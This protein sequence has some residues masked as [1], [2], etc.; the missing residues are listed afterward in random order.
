MQ[1]V[2]LG[3][4]IECPIVLCLG[5]F[6]SMHKGHVELLNRAK[7][8]AQATNCK[9]ALF[10]FNNNHLAVLKRDAKLLY[11]LNERLLIYESLNIDYVITANF[12]AD[13]R[14]LSGNQ[15][16]SEFNQYNLQSVFCGFDHCCGRDH[17][18]ALGIQR[19]F[20]RIPVHIVEQ[21]SVDGQKVSTTL[22]REYVVSNQIEKANTLLSEPFFLMGEVV[23]GR[24]VGK[25][26]GFP[27]ANI[28]IPAD[29]LLPIGVFGGITNIDGISYRVIANI[30][31]TPTF[32]IERNAFEVHV[33][34]FDGNL[35]GNILKVSL[36][37]YLRPITKF[38]SATALAQQ[39]QLDKENTIND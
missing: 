20:N 16:L 10:T 13:F 8:Y 39:L 14:S 25:T 27:T 29:K 19:F 12:D 28:Q 15:F 38:D 36:T 21:V 30:G 37:K 23:H 9:V 17:L 5:F 31:H 2:K 34:D 3:E 11:T 7:S 6:G 1:I 18:D 35:Y 33:I 24:G 4:N 22:L 26:L 32:D